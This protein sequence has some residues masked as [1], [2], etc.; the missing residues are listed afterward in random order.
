MLFANITENIT[1]YN[2]LQITENTGYIQ[3]EI[4]NTDN[5]KINKAT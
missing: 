4:E 2:N 3:D 5:L 1:D